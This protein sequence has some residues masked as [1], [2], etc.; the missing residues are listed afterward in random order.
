MGSWYRF[1]YLRGLKIYVENGFVFSGFCRILWLNFLLDY[2]HSG[3]SGLHQRCE[4]SREIS[5]YD[6]LQVKS[7]SQIKNEDI[8]AQK[9]KKKEKNQEKMNKKANWPE[10]LC[11][12]NNWHSSASACKTQKES[13]RYGLGRSVAPFPRLFCLLWLLCC[14]SSCSATTAADHN[15]GDLGEVVLLGT[16]TSLDLCVH[17]GPPRGPPVRK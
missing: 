7:D 12:V 3:R 5:V 6:T 14:A 13:S 4:R 17:T 15:D 9:E 16:K 11:K 1:F 2:L 8:N 10:R